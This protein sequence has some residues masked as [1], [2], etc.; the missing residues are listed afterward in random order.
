[1]FQDLFADICM[2]FR[3]SKL[4]NT[5]PT[6]FREY[7]RPQSSQEFIDNILCPYAEAFETVTKAA[8]EGC[9]GTEIVNSMLLWLNQFEH[10]DWIPS[11]MHYLVRNQEN[12]AALAEFFT[13][14]ERLTTGLMLLRENASKRVERFCQVLRAIDSNQNLYA[15]DSPLQ[16]RPDEQ[17]EI[18]TMFKGDLSSIQGRPLRY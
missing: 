7:V 2:I 3:K 9:Q 8:Y 5:I 15:F 14:L 4:Q 17:R 11:A 18:L 6:E 13:G 12:P 16:L 10:S 1:M